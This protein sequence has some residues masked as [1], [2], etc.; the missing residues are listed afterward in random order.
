MFFVEGQGADLLNEALT[1]RAIDGAGVSADA[2]PCL[3]E[4]SKHRQIVM[5]K[6]ENGELLASLACAKIS[7]YALRVLAANP[8]HKLRPYEYCEGKILFVVDGFFRKNACRKAL[9]VLAPQFARSRLIAFVRNGKLRVF[10][11]HNGKAR[12][13]TLAALSDAAPESATERL[14]V[15]AVG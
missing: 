12:R 10:Y 2:L 3:L 4:A 14:P 5:A 9:A 1:L 11:N 15:R 6:A 13:V 7:K 8:A